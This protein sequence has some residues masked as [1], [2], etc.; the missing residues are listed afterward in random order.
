[1]SRGRKRKHLVSSSR[2]VRGAVTT[3]LMV[4]GASVLGL[5]VDGSALV[6]LGQE[7]LDF[8]IVLLDADGKLEVFAGDRV[9]VLCFVS[10]A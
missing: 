10:K 9:P 2:V 7:L 8:P 6:L 1:M 5:V 4:D 3:L